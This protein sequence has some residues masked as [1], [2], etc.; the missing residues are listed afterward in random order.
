VLAAAALLVAG[1]VAAGIAAR[2]R[3]PSLVLVLGLGMLVADDGLEWITF[4]DAELAQ[5]LSVVAL[6]LILYDGGLSTPVA[7]LRRVLAP[8]AS[9]ATVGVVATMS[10]VAGAVI[11]LTDVS[12]STAWIIGAVVA[13]TDAAAV[14]VAMRDVGVS[15]R[16]TGTL[17]AESG[18]ND[19]L[20]VLLTIGTIEVAIGDVGTGDWLAFGLRQLGLGLVV[21]LVVG[22]LGGRIVS[23]ARLASAALKPVLALAVG[24]AA[25]GGAA[26]VGGSSFLSVFVA[27]VAVSAGAPGHR[28]AI[29]QFHEG[30]AE[31]AQIG[32]FFLLGVLVFPSDLI[33]DLGVGLVVTV[34]LVVVARP[35]G[36]LVS[37]VWFRFTG[38]ELVF[39]SWAGLRGAVP[40]V[41]GTYPLTAGVEDGRLVFDVVFVVVLVS[42]I[43]QG[44]SLGPMAR[45]LGLER[46]P[47]PRELAVDVV[48]LGST[49]LDVAEVELD[50]GHPF[51]GRLLAEVPPPAPVRVALV[52]RDGSAFVPGGG[53]RLEAGDVLVVG[54]TAG[55]LD[56][57]A[58]EAWM[59]PS[60]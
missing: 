45:R 26:A 40:I 57:R 3:V 11:L 23:R 21:G 49:A 56:A 10:V 38:R 29:R 31:A 18:L 54:V 17:Q 44:T 41:L 20:A 39:L 35:V 28:R 2:L 14:F 6:L 50:D 27:G 60:A 46:D 7:S 36:V 37:V 30:L 25:Y 15:R 47:T 55:T 34:A 59:T 43:V 16:L 48:P 13:S 42:T 12:T 4:D 22:T 58:V 53:T 19:P 9:L 1:V 24:A 51:V 33:D 8:A 32:L 5:N 52:A